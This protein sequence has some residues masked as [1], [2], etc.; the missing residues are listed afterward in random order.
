MYFI[1]SDSPTYRLSRS[2]PLVSSLCLYVLLSWQS[3][4]AQNSGKCS[5]LPGEQVSGELATLRTQ[6]N[7]SIYRRGEPVTVT[8]TLKAGANGVYLPDYFGDFMKT[9]EHGFAAS[10]LTVAGKAADAHEPGC[11]GGG[12]ESGPGVDTA[13]A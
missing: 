6:V 3:A 8:L 10:L 9:C 7:R 13:E 4:F 11:V 2:N 1:R 5:I 12:L